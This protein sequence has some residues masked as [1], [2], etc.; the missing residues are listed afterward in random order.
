MKKI[1]LG[2][3]KVAAV[4]LMLTVVAAF[5]LYIEGY[6]D[7]TFLPRG[8]SES[9]QSVDI[10][11]INDT[12]T[13]SDYSD[14]YT[15]PSQAAGNL[16]NVTSPD[17]IEISA[18]TSKDESDGTAS[19]TT[20]S[21]TSY[22]D[23]SVS[24][25]SKATF[26]SMTSSIPTASELKK[27]GY[28]LTGTDYSAST[29]R[30]AKVTLQVKVPSKYS[31]R[32]VESTIIS[33]ETR[34]AV[35]TS[36]VNSRPV[37][38]PYMGWIIYDDGENLNLMDE[39]GKL[40]MTQ[41][42]AVTPAYFRDASG[43]LLFRYGDGLYYIAADGSYKMYR[44]E[45][46]ESFAPG[47]RFDSSENY[48]TPNSGLYLYYV[49]ENVSYVK[50]QNTIDKYIAEGNEPPDPVVVTEMTRLYGYMRADGTIA[51]KAQ[52][53]YA[54]NFNAN[55]LACVAGR[56]RIMKLINTS[57]TAVYDPYGTILY[58]PELNRRPVIKCYMLP[59]TDGE[60]NIGAYYFDNGYIRVNRVYLDYYNKDIIV[61]SSDILLDVDGNEFSYPQGYNLAYYSDG[62]LI[63]EKNGYYGALDLTG[64]WIAQPIYTYFTPFHEG[65]AV[66]GFKD[67]KKAMIDTSGNIVLPFAY[68]YISS[69]SSGVITAFESNN[70]WMIYQK[71]AIVQN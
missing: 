40:A 23:T 34:E 3:A 30:I 17:G 37:L 13:T 15:I 59:F 41:F 31:L 11:Q 52:Y 42:D 8:D 47:L 12:N 69:V 25:A 2:T 18:D 29:H 26:A 65:L 10:S 21:E 62:V 38:E 57:G 50:N 4:L 60:E 64:K 66:I 36:Y 68:D 32:T 5:I 27:Q 22:A 16:S 53:N 63:L 20:K 9:D 6:Y 24:S 39:N 70:G 61:S 35:E 28:T 56:D 51:I 43:N 46:D 54:T 49:D 67:G 33:Y 71:M 48:G 1:L 7:F 45:Y 14:D 58:L 19:E 55:G 44:S